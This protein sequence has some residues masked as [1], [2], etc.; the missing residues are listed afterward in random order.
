M[1]VFAPF[2]TGTDYFGSR[3]QPFMPNFRVTRDSLARPPRAREATD[4]QPS[5]R[6][7]RRRP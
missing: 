3:E 7:R 6:A 4:P 5:V 2:P 1:T